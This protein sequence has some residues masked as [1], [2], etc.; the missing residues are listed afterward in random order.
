MSSQADES[1]KNDWQQSSSWDGSWSAGNEQWAGTIW[2]ER[3]PNPS[4]NSYYGDSKRLVSSKAGKITVP[5]GKV[6]VPSMEYW[7][8]S[9]KQ[10]LASIPAP[11]RRNV[12]SRSRSAR[13]SSSRSSSIK[14]P[15]VF[16]TFCGNYVKVF[17][18]LKYILLK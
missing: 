3:K 15:D 16:Y 11:P 18:K 2:G 14:R 7:G 6:R 9:N 5:E 13:R 10:E 12:R 1:W 17:K 8:D 4:P